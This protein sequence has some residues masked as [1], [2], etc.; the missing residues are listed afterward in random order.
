MI[1]SAILQKPL[2]VSKDTNLLEMLMIFEEKKATMAIITDEMRKKNDS[3]HHHSEDLFFSVNILYT[4]QQKY[5]QREEFK[6]IC[7]FY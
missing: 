5:K 4:I 1:N 3:H 2:L 7:L 6:S